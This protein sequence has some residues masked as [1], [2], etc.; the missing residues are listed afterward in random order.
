V[1]SVQSEM[2]SW[3]SGQVRSHPGFASNVNQLSIHTWLQP[4]E[5]W[6][7]PKWKPSRRFPA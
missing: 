6:W 7:N 4:G 1:G 2:V 5:Q 3:S